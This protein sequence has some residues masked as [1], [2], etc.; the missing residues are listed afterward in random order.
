ME[1]SFLMVAKTLKG[2]EAT[3]A[4]ELRALGAANVEPGH[5][6][7]S[8]EGDLTMLYRANLCLRTALRILKPFYSFEATNT[9]ELYD[10]AKEYDWS[11]I[12]SSDST[13]AVDVVANSDNFTHTR[14]ATYR[15]KDAIVDWF[16]DRFDA[17]PSVRLS[18]ADIIFNVHIQGDKV[19]LAL[20]SSGESLHKR[21]WRVATTDAPINEVLAAGILLM[22]GY[23]GSK[24]LVDP[25]CGSGT[26]LVEAALIAA[27]INPG[28]FRQNYAFRRWKDY[29]E[30]LF[31]S[32]WN[33][34]SQERE[35]T[36]LIMGADM[37]RAAVEATS[38]NLKAAGVS[39]Y[40]SVETRNFAD[41]T[42]APAEQGILVMNPPYGERISAPD[43]EALYSTIGSQLKKLFTGWNA[44]IISVK[45]EFFSY[46]GLAPSQKISLLN[47]S[48]DCELREYVMFKGN[49]REF[50]AAG[51]KLKEEK[52]DEKTSKRQFKGAPAA[53]KD[54]RPFGRRRDERNNRFERRPDSDSKFRTEKKFAPKPEIDLGYDASDETPL[55][56]R[57]NLP[58]L[59]TIM[60]R[61]PVQ[62][63][64]TTVMRSRGWKKKEQQ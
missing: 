34:D 16:R 40:V 28:V 58:L 2:L 57:R 46:V 42:Q 9:D 33:D 5:R 50:R 30:E 31:E 61:E 27:N 56:K 20:D 64:T 32:L 44:W 19:T 39:K 22:S 11:S 41:W 63:P 47:G 15:V 54:D 45:D 29:D 3:L 51:G 52:K 6:M 36:S 53:K 24:P 17:R 7:V 26:F 23:D 1:S 25:M 43:M 14:F 35:P 38:R 12:M 48:I 13:F 21:G 55:A 62:K 49:K 60:S 4:D 37:L 59:R 18:D 10:R 8:F